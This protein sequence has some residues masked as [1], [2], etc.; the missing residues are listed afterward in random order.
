[1]YSFCVFRLEIFV[2]YLFADLVYNNFVCSYFIEFYNIFFLDISIFC[3]FYFNE[4]KVYICRGNVGFFKMN[5][6][7]NRIDFKGK[8]LVWFKESWL[9][10]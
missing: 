7:L 6:I 9:K 4:R 10:Y 5:E 3:E 2:S 8:Y 1:M